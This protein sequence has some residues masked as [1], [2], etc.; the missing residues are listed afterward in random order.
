VVSADSA[1]LVAAASVDGAPHIAPLALPPRIVLFD[2]VCGLCQKTVR[3][4]IDHDPD[5]A[6]WFAPLQGET[7]AALRRQH[8]EI[9]TEIHT[10]VFVEEGR[11]FLRSKVFLY[12]AR[13]LPRPWRWAYHFRWL[14]A[15]PLDLAYRLVAR[16]RY[17][18]WG[19]VDECRLPT[20][21]D[22]A[23]LLP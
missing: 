21:E 18:I 14:P 9:P 11:V 6:F 5:R 19:T 13:H 3:W 20:A 1:G 10:V 12:A 15:W 2:G 17:R 8:P 16:L 23:R 22:R 4:L 7:A